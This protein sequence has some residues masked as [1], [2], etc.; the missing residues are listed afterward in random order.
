[1]NSKIPRSTTLER[2]GEIDDSSEMR[3]SCC[4]SVMIRCDQ[5][6]EENLD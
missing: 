2:V 4:L 6:R 3:P 1:M 5:G